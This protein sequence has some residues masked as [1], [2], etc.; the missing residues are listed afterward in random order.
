MTSSGTAQEKSD[1]MDAILPGLE[2]VTISILSS[3]TNDALERYDSANFSEEDKDTLRRAR[4]V[5]L[6]EIER[7]QRI[8]QSPGIE[9]FTFRGR[10]IRRAGYM[11]AKRATGKEGLDLLNYIAQIRATLDAIGEECANLEDVEEAKRFFEE[12]K[13]V[14]NCA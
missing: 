12:A 6:D 14:Y 8:L 13:S 4:R 9:G 3:R 5:I 11:A 1:G 7:N 10:R 2:M